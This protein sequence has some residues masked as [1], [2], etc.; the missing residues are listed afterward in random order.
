MS[1][2][3]WSASRVAWEIPAV[4]RELIKAL[5]ATG[6][7][8]VLVLMN[9]RPLSIAWER[10]QADAILETWSILETWFSGTE[11]GNAIADV[12]FGDYNPSGKLAI[13]FP[14]SVGQIP[15][16]YNHLSIGRPYTPGK[17]GNYTSQYFE[18]PNGPLYPFGYGLSYSQFELSDLALSKTALKHGDTLQAEVT[19]KNTGTFDGETVVQLYVQDVSASMSRP[20]KELK[21]FQKVLLKAGEARTLTFAISEDDLK[22]YNG[23]LQH[24][25]EPGQ[26]NV[27]VGLDSQAV[28]QQSF[29]LL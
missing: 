13:T 14:R 19:V 3:P 15:M 7:P 21:H 28:Q 22:F 1:W 5:K 29:E 18:E 23:Q 6:K 27:Q 11:G 20:V 4:Q 24:V 17:P 10:E 26:F 9:G 12:L 2:W 8:L 25:A 16:Y